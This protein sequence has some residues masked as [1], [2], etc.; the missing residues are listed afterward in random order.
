ML[1]MGP[2]MEGASHVDWGFVSKSSQA[3]P[4]LPWALPPA[5]RGHLSDAVDR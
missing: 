5:H 4:W 1:G 3:V 2:H